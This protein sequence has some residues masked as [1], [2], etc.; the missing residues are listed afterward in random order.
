MVTHCRWPKVSRLARA[1]P[2]WPPDPQALAAERDD[3]L[4]PPGGAAVAL[5]ESD[6]ML[7]V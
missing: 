2:M 5:A 3:R 6:A 7:N 1:P 4:V